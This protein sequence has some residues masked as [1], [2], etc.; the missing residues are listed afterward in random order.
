MVVEPEEDEDDWTQYADAGYASAYDPWADLVDAEEEADEDEQSEDEFDDFDESELRP[1]DIPRCPAPGGVAHAIRIGTCDACLGRVSGARIAGDPL[2]TVGARVRGEATERDADLT[3]DEGVECCPFCEDLFVEIDLIAE[4]IASAIEGI[5]FT[6]AQLGA[7]FSKAHVAAEEEL[8]STLAA[9]GS[10]PLKASLTETVQAAV[11]ELVPGMVWVKEK[12]EVMLLLDTL[13]LGVNVDIRALFVYG[14]YL[15]LSREIPQTRWPCRACRGAGCDSCEGTGQQ[16][17]ASIQSLVCEPM[18]AAFGAESDAFHG[19]GREDIN[20]H[21][22]GQG[23][24]FVAEIKRPLTR[25]VDLA[26]LAET[27]NAAADGQIKIHGLRPSNRAEVARIKETKAEKSYT[28]RFSCE[29]GFSEEEATARLLTL[30]GKTLEQQT[31]QRVS[32]RRADKI[33]KRKVVALDDIQFKD[34]EIQFR[35]RCESG[36]YVKEL[37]H[38]DEGRTTPSVSGVLEADCEVLWLDVEDIHAD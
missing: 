4:R 6:K 35:V 13:T 12:P 2:T 18:V 38:S 8:R 26:A 11:I 33:R 21:C 3:V 36:T 14:R 24:P 37:V 28:I 19:M 9:T 7:H 29:H 17:P 25:T 32:H 16:Y 27:I 15:K 23:R 31:P 1:R 5:E 30:A 34:G 22:L 10:R 20:V